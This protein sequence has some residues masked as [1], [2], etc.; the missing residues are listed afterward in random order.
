MST[1]KYCINPLAVIFI[2]E[3]DKKNN[4]TT[5]V[6]NPE[7]ENILKVKQF[8]YE[9]LE[10]IDKNPRLNSSQ[11]TSIVSQKR[12]VSEW[13]NESKIV[14]FIERMVKENIVFER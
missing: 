2:P 8:G 12:Q 14:G 4:F 7:T 13:Q 3:I 9:I 10:T 1:D 11:I 5:I 6:F